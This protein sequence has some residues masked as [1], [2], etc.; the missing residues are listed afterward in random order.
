M[1]ITAGT[2]SG[3]TE[4]FLPAGARVAARG[5][6]RRGAALPRQSFRGGAH[7][8]GAFRPQRDGEIS[9]GAR[10]SGR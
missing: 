9:G 6:A 5:I 10:P 1:V 3:K 4:S 8:R 2:G 7:R